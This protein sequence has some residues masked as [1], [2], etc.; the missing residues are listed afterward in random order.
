MLATFLPSSVQSLNHVARAWRSQRTQARS[1]TTKKTTAAAVVPKSTV[2][3]TCI[4][5]S[6]TRLSSRRMKFLEPGSLSQTKLAQT[7][8]SAL[9]RILNRR[10]VDDFSGIVFGHFV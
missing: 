3:M 5:S 7:Q 2:K 4:K 1:V 8:G 6:R 9:Q 10:L